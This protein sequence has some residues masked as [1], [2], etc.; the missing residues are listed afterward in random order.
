M[1]DVRSRNLV[2]NHLTNSQFC[3]IQTPLER[4]EQEVLGLA[5]P[6][7]HPFSMFL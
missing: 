7:R 6:D 5:I 2:L 4:H 1:L 3:R